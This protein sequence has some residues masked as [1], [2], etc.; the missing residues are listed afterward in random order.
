MTP[1]SISKPVFLFRALEQG[2][3]EDCYVNHK[4]DML[5]HRPGL[6]W[7]C[8]VKE[9]T[10]QHRGHETTYMSYP[11]WLLDNFAP[12]ITYILVQTIPYISVNFSPQS[13]H[14]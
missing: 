5:K 7:W 13:R 8:S 11:G 3:Q 14:I 1:Q 9:S 6:P 10:R 4:W 2:I 12:C